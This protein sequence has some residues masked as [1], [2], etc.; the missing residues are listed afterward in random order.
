MVDPI[1]FP[2]AKLNNEKVTLSF[3]PATKADEDALASLIP[4]GI[5]D[6]S[7]LPTSIPSYLVSVK[8][9]LKVNGTTV[10]TGSPMSLGEELNFV[11]GNRFAGRGYRVNP[12]TYKVVAGSYLNVNVFAGSISPT[13]LEKLQTKL[14]S[15]KSILESANQ[16]TIASLTRDD[17]LGDMFYA[18]GLGYYAQLLSLS[19]ISGLKA[20][21]YYQLAVGYGTVGYEPEVNSFF[22]FP[23]GI[24]TGGVA[25]DIPMIN[26]IANQ[27]G[28]AEKA[29]QF[30]LQVG[31]LGSALEHI[32][33]EQMFAPTDPN[34]PKPDAISAVKALQKASA[35][36]QKIYQI[37]QSNMNQILPLLHHDRE[38]LNEI[39]RALNVGKDV[40]THTDAVSI[41]GGWSGFGYIITDPVVGDGVYKISGGLN[42]GLVVLLSFIGTFLLIAG[43][44]L[45]ASV[46][47]APIGIGLILAGLFFLSTAVAI[48]SMPNS[49]ASWSDIANGIGAAVA[50]YSAIAALVTGAGLILAL[51]GLIGALI[52]LLSSI[53]ALFRRSNRIFYVVAAE[54]LNYS[55]RYCYV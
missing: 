5:T 45:V 36:G 23:R 21:G 28:D 38:T 46:A 34:A 55:R 47:F 7:Q 29:K 27:E 4:E 12:R 40:T 24:K 32:T 49:S 11:T 41:P 42:G 18:G 6:V 26:V 15:T 2:F 10:K 9:E 3:K 19:Y 39:K 51:V 54:F 25:F 50:V 14:K 8:P 31:T 43:I 22:G 17:I 44:M 37:N 20:K 53:F 52:S 33:P 35:A 30:T 16:T 1:S 48:V 13:K